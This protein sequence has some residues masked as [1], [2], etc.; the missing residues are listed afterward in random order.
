M[1]YTHYQ[2]NVSGKVEHKPEEPLHLPPSISNTCQCALLPQQP[3]SPARSQL[4]RSA[5]CS[6]QEQG[7]L[8]RGILTQLLLSSLTKTSSHASPSTLNTRSQISDW[9][10]MGTQLTELASGSPMPCSKCSQ[11]EKTE[12]TLYLDNR[13]QPMAILVTSTSVIL[14]QPFFAI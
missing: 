12:A 2:S 14:P 1:I 7:H 8:Q 11:A 6:G 13:P 3:S 10:V 5:E 9:L 4:L